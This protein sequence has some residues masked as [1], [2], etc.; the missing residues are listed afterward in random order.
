AEYENPAGKILKL[1][2]ASD[3][4]LAES[5]GAVRILFDPDGNYLW[6]AAYDLSSGW[7]HNNKLST[8]VGGITGMSLRLA[9][10]SAH[11]HALT[12]DTDGEIIRYSIYGFESEAWEGSY[13]LVASGEGG[14]AALAIFSSKVL[15]AYI[16]AKASWFYLRVGRISGDPPA[17]IEDWNAGR[18]MVSRKGNLIVAPSLA[19]C[20]YNDASWDPTNY[21]QNYDLYERHY[22]GSSWSAET[23]IY[24]GGCHTPSG[25]YCDGV[26]HV[27]FP[28]F[29][30]GAKK[31]NL[32]YLYEITNDGSGWSDPRLL[33][34]AE[35]Y[36]GGGWKIEGSGNT[37]PI[38]TTGGGWGT[39]FRVYNGSEHRLLLYADGLKLG[40]PNWV[41]FKTS[42][43][44]PTT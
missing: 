19:Y 29:A 34:D 36:D 31:G 42:G 37:F 14:A 4:E 23:K 8:M 11:A 18:Y 43:K 24:T 6:H 20:I 21:Y 13:T 5:E 7:G 27:F 28:T 9:N 10:D 30:G 40:S 33:F 39:T 3:A 41:T 2:I 22:N 35:A 25:L 38:S 17:F 12:G 1:G 32:K 44:P 16:T 15:A 26:L